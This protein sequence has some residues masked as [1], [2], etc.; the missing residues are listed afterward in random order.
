MSE[1]KKKSI[2]KPVQKKV[3][4]QPKEN[5]LNLDDNQELDF[6]GFPKDVSLKRNIG[7]GG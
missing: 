3:L 6:G 5:E 2:E 4:K 1:K 7:C